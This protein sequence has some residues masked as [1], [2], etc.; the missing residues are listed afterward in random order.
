MHEGLTGI[1]GV[2]LG[3]LITRWSDRLA[4]SA[5]PAMDACHRHFRRLFPDVRCTVAQ[6][7][8]AIECILTPSW[9]PAGP[10][11]SL[12]ARLGG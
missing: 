2:E 10:N 7:E 11:K 3:P 9:I 1:K 6:T 12:R 8:A 4:T 5:A